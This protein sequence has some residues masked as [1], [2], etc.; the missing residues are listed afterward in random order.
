[1]HMLLFDIVPLHYDALL[2]SFDELLQ[3]FEKEAFRLLTKPHLHHLLDVTMR[4]E[5]LYVLTWVIVFSD[6][7]IHPLD[8]LVRVCCR[9]VTR[10]ALIPYTYSSLLK[11]FYPFVDLSLMHGACSIL[12]QHRAMDFHRFNPLCLQKTHYGVL[13]L[14]DAVTEWSGHTLFSLLS[15][16]LLSMYFVN[17]KLPWGSDSVSIKDS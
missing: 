11:M 2:V 15:T 16:V 8:V 4:A 3:P 7:G 6:Q 12:C 10:S 9:W 17:F 13:F 5:L 14:D 1:M